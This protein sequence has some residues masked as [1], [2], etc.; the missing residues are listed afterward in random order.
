MLN[1]IFHVSAL[2]V[3]SLDESL[4]EVYAVT[5]T[6]DTQSEFM[7]TTVDK[8]LDSFKNVAVEFRSIPT[9]QRV[10]LYVSYSSEGGIPL[11][12]PCVDQS[13][14]RVPVEEPSKGLRGLFLALLTEAS[15]WFIGFSMILGLVILLLICCCSPRNRNIAHPLGPATPGSP[16][17]PPYGGTPSA[18]TPYGTPGGVYQGDNQYHGGDGSLAPRHHFRH[19]T[20]ETTRRSYV[21]EKDAQNMSGSVSLG[22][23]SPGRSPNGLFSVTQ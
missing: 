7:V 12:A 16:A 6:D 8:K 2:Q 5:A 1:E 22:R 18:G 23:V 19:T 10:L 17:P 21:S 20:Q 4:V 13:C 15:A 14:P 11:A 3:R 9:G